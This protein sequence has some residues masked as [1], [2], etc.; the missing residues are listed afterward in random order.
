MMIVEVLHQTAL[1][2]LE[3]TPNPTFLDGILY[4]DF[5]VL[6]QARRELDACRA[7]RFSQ[8]ISPTRI[9]FRVPYTDSKNAP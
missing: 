6:R 2:R 5:Q 3:K 1:S 8:I 4:D 9:W 7:N